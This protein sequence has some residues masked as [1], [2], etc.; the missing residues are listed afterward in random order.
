MLYVSDR[1]LLEMFDL[2]HITCIQVD[3]VPGKF[4]RELIEHFLDNNRVTWAI[5][6]RTIAERVAAHLAQRGAKLIAADVQSTLRPRISRHDVLL[7]VQPGQRISP[8]STE[9]GPVRWTLLQD[10]NHVPEE[11]I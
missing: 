4:A 7:Y 11:C 3:S 10:A 2:E 5:L 8:D 9:R 1:L 6:D